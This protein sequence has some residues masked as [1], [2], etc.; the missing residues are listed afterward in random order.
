MSAAAVAAVVAMI[1][2]AVYYLA[3]AGVAALAA[4]ETG[5]ESD[6]AVAAARDAAVAQ[7]AAVV[8]AA[9]P[10]AVG[11][12]D[13]LGAGDASALVPGG[14]DAN[15]AG[16]GWWRSRHQSEWPSC[17]ARSGPLAELQRGQKLGRRTA[18]AGN[19]AEGR[20]SHSSTHLGR[21]RLVVGGGI[22]RG[23]AMGRWEV[24]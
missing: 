17:R 21:R 18:S 11:V 20:C 23:A 7:V 5:V 22:C 9:G 16:A 15:A 24:D 12:L 14:P 6:V 4:A 8:A 19:A 13:E 1:A 2:A 10:G 3:G